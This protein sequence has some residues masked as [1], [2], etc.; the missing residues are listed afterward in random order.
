MCLAVFSYKT[1]ADF[2][3]ILATNRDE[4]YSREAKPAHFW[5]D[6]PDLLAGKDTKAGGTWL[7]IT[8]TN[9]FAA[10]TNY[11]D[12]DRIKPDAPSRGDLVKNYLISELSVLEYYESVQS[13]LKRYNGFNLILGQPDDLYYFNNQKPGLQKLTPGFYSLSNAFLNTSWPKTDRALADLKRMFKDGIPSKERLLQLLQNKQRYPNE[14]LP[15]TGLRPEMERVVSSIFITSEE[16]GTRCS[17]LIYVSRNGDTEFT[18]VTYHP[19]STDP[20]HTVTFQL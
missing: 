2:P 13:D 20:V 1:E 6:Y 18:E 15:E 8:K 14:L 3:L 12:I 4:F 7:G 16:Y 10:I 17:T 9:R 5:D 11:R 19:G